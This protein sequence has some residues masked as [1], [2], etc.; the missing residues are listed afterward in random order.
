MPERDDPLW[1]F[2][3][4]RLP[5]PPSSR[6]LGWRCVELDVARGTI[7]V[8]FA[9]K[10]E[11]LNPAGGIAGGFIAHM[12]DA[13]IGPGVA[14]TLAPG[15]FP[16]TVEFKVCFLR[17]V[18]LGTVIGRAR[19]VH[20]GEAMVF[21]EGDLRDPDNRLLAT[22]TATLRIVTIPNVELDFGQGVASHKV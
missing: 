1:H 3:H 7:A 20:R 13:T 5:G 12:L 21:A 6:F 17:P 11:C 18:R 22:A 19:I 4:N 15:Q 16:T 14:I 9:P 10:P 8:E 2:V